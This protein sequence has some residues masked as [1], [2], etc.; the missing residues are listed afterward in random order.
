[1]ARA[2]PVDRFKMVT[3]YEDRPVDTYTLA[4]GKPK[5]RKTSDPSSRTGCNAVRSPGDDPETKQ[6]VCQNITMARFAEWLRDVAP[7]NRYPVLDATGLNGA[8]DFTLTF[9]RLLTLTGGNCAATKQGC[10]HQRAGQASDPVTG[11]SLFD[12]LEKQ[13]GLKLEKHKRPER[14]VVIDHIEDHP[15]EN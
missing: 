1:M 6:Y 7:S 5:L 14:V 11:L 4:A 13:L 3:H 10:S 2:L 15:T 12:A 9:N 8:L